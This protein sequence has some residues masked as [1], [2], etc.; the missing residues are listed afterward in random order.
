M[1]SVLQTLKVLSQSFGLFKE[2]LA[3]DELDRPLKIGSVLHCVLHAQERVRKLPVA[4]SH[5]ECESHFL[6]FRLLSVTIH[7]LKNVDV[8]KMKVQLSVWDVRFI[9]S[10]NRHRLYGDIITTSPWINKGIYSTQ[11]TYL[12]CETN[13]YATNICVRWTSA[14]WIFCVRLRIMEKIWR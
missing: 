13:Y 4:I 7:D 3:T 11:K 9:F 8:V 2:K 1:R 14:M 12:T 5:L 6:L 10:T